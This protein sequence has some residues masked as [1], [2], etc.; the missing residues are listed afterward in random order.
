METLIRE[1]NNEMDWALSHPYLMV[2]KMTT[3]GVAGG[4]VFFVRRIF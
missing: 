3:P 4:T 2:E 1:K